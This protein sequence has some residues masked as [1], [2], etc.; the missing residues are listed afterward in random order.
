MFEKFVKLIVVVIVCVIGASVESIFKEPVHNNISLETE[1]GTLIDTSLVS[2]VDGDTAKFMVNGE[3]QTIRFLAIDTPETKK[4]NTDVQPFGLEASEFTC[5]VLTTA[6]K[7]TLELE[8]R[9]QYDKYD[10]LL[11]WVFVD[12][13][14]LQEMIVSEGLAKVAYL[15]DDYKYI[16]N[17][18]RVESI[19]KDN[20]LNIWSD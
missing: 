14:L 3:K 18:Q 7:I 11:A 8:Q 9:N 5:E 10:R 15:Y 4:P 17:I 19:A 20:K 13:E 16:N 6:D 2:C 12:G 1:R